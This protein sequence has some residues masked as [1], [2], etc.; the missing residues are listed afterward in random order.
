M[1]RQ[2]R[3]QNDQAPSEDQI[4]EGQRKSEFAPEASSDATPSPIPGAPEMSSA[5]LTPEQFHEQLQ[6]SPQKADQP[7]P[8][9]GHPEQPQYVQPDYHPIPTRPVTPPQSSVGGD[10]KPGGQEMYDHPAQ[11]PQYGGGDY[12]PQQQPPSQPY[13]TG[14]PPMAPPPQPPKRDGMPVWAWVLPLLIILLG[15]GGFGVW[16]YISSQ[17]KPTPEA[18][19]TATVRSQA[20]ASATAIEIPFATIIAELATPTLPAAVIIEPVR[21]PV[22]EFIALYED[23]AKRPIIVDVRTAQSFAEGH[24]AGAVSIP[25]A[26]TESRLSELPKDKLIV[27]YCQ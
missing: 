21:M 4:A 1:Y 17:G 18:Q 19:A 22:E 3:P 16:A 7:Q 25:D 12:Y 26:D 27:A 10:Y 8:L 15:A 5:P 20:G 13:Y 2:D 9:Y 11:P 23:P 6:Q 24:I 14:G